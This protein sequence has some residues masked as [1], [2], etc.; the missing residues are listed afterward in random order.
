MTDLKRICVFTGS[1]RGLRSEYLDAARALGRALVERDYELVYGGGNIGL[2]GVIADTVLEARGHVIGVIPDGLVSKEVA[3]PGLSELHVVGSM[4]ERKSVMAKLA[5]GFVGLPGGL[6]TMEEFFEVYTWAQ[7]GMHVKPCGLLNVCDYYKHILAFI[8]HAVTEE[9]VK[10]VNRTMLVVEEE[11][12]ALLDRFEQYTPPS[13][14][15]WLDG[16]K[17]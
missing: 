1:S 3:H 5:D 7:L 6:G 11:P 10:P 14:Y 8:D 17:I 2:M 13:I 9:F 16:S 15:K 4:H 12:G